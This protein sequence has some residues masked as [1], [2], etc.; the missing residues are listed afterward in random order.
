[1]IEKICGFK[2]SSFLIYL[3]TF[4]FILF[5]ENIYIKK[6]NN[7]LNNYNTKQLAYESS[8]YLI[9]FNRILFKIR[10]RRI[11][12]PLDLLLLTAIFNLI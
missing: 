12:T 11:Q 4:S 5:F 10:N 9:N 2:L 8:P 6:K 7:D 3:S 1:M